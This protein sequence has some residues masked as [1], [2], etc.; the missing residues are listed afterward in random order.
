[1]QSN[2]AGEPTGGSPNFIGDE[3][4]FTLPYSKLGANVSDIYWQESWA[5]DY[6]TWI[7]PTLFAPPT[8]AAFKAKRDPAMEAILAYREEG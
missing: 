8:F 7:A 6:R 1:M 3:V 5:T 2:Y 4:F